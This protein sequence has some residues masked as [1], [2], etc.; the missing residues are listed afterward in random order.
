VYRIGKWV[1]ARWILD[2]CCMYLL[3]LNTTY[4][5]RL[6]NENTEY[7]HISSQLKT[8]NIFSTVNKI[9]PTV[10][11]SSLYIQSVPVTIKYLRNLSVLLDK[12]RAFADEKEMKHEEMLKFRLI[13]DMQG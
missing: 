8:P 2:Q 5:R 9:F 12:G 6:L 7:N 3:D 11:M 10:K 1:N 4:I 13:S